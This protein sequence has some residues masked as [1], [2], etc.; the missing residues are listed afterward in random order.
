MSI[1]QDNAS[2]EPTVEPVVKEVPVS[3]DVKTNDIPYARFKEV[4]EKSIA[5]QEKL[6]AMEAKVKK[7]RDSELEK[8]GEYKTLL[9]EVNLELASTK[10]KADEWTE[11]QETRRK[12]LI[13]QLP[14]ADRELYGDMPMDK[15]EVHVSKQSNF[16]NVKVDNSDPIGSIGGYSTPKEVLDAVRNKTITNDQGQGI[17]DRFRKKLDR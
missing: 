3:T 4:N 16:K 14:E 6:D 11:Y 17:I 9:D 5:L 15:L 10:L 2:V 7:A 13:E 8:Q 1:T 12:T